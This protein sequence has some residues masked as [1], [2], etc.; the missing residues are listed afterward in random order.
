M[1]DHYL[2][3]AEPV[4]GY[5][6]SSGSKFHAYLFPIENESDAALYLLQLKKQ[7]PKARHFCTA[8]RLYADGSL[9]RSSD[10]GEPFGSAG[11]PML[12]QLVKENLTQVFAVVVR[13]FGGT[14]LGIPGLIEAYRLSTLDALEKAEKI[15]RQVYSVVEIGVS[16]ERYSGFINLIRQRQLL[17]LD[18]VFGE[19]VSLRLAFEKANSAHLLLDILRAYSH[20]DFEEIG[21]YAVALGF[22]ISFLDEEVVR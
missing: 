10:D 7:H 2:T 9:E 8:L 14:K 20:L 15:R 16:F 21:E 11:K 12:G 6:M 18:E 17:L 3:I 4:E 22:E 1:T 13:Y 5:F 19:N